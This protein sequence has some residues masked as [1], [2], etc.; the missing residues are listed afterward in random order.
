MITLERVPPT[1]RAN[2]DATVTGTAVEHD[3]P[4]LDDL[5]VR[6]TPGGGRLRVWS[7]NATAM[8]LCLFATKD[9]NW[10]SRRV[11]LVRDRNGVWSASSEFLV[12]GAHYSVRAD[13][14]AGPVHA[15]DPAVHLIDPYARGL[16]RTRAGWRSVVHDDAFDWGQVGKPATRLKDTVIY[17]AHV[18][19]ISKLNPDI[20]QRLRGSYAGLAHPSMIAYLQRLG[21]TA[22]ELLPVQQFTTEQRLVKQGLSN[23][24]GYNTVNFFMP[25]TAYASRGAQATG[26]AAVIREFKGMVRLLHEAGIE[27]ILDVVYNH[28]AEEGRDNPTLSLRG[29]DNASYYRQNAKGDYL[30]VTG[31]GNTLDSSTGAVQRLILDSLRY[32]ANE[33]QVDGFRFD[34]AAALGRG[35][36]DG[37]GVGDFDREH[38]LLTAIVNDPQLAGVK[39]IAEPW[40]VGPGGWQ[41]G[42][43]PDG[44]AEW[45][46]RY[47]DR[48]RDFWLTDIAAVRAAGAPIGI[49]PLAAR[50]AGSADIFAPRRSP[51]ASMNF[52]TA[53]DGFT[54]ADLVSFNHKHNVGNGEN[55]NDGTDHNHS[56]NHGVEGATADESIL[57][58]RRKAM[59]NLLGTL[60]FSAGVPMITAGD[61]FGHSQRG[62]NNAYCQDSELTW[63]S[64]QRLPWQQKLQ[65][66]T[67][68]LIRLR[69][70]HPAL[71][72]ADF[73]VLGKTVTTASRLDWFNARGYSMSPQDWNS[74]EARTLQ[75]LTAEASQE[76]GHDRILLVIHGLEEATTVRLPPHE[77][78]T[79]YVLL[80]DSAAETATVRAPSDATGP[81]EW[82]ETETG[83]GTSFAP[84]TELTVPGTSM[85]LFH[86]L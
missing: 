85:R 27:V 2:T 52:V 64:W 16:T 18:K 74:P 3:T 50:L 12:A 33:M 8:E 60:L 39:L 77:S 19:G 72:P 62:N 1:H 65:S 69:R 68:E 31:C 63:L 73:G 67:S 44:W 79:S 42:N 9:P 83:T 81:G 11:P 38:P 45:N 37:V 41:V 29:L 34:L 36:G 13:G 48:V 30:D 4:A 59:R 66:V 40:D 46:D 5:G 15:F 61:E 28:T 26:P 86:A 47:R 53:H 70:E 20:P 21:I 82:T 14:P 6:L 80:W 56:F 76:E 78:V 84:G 25:H 32:W 24:W 7:A 17:E 22:V 54:L 58:A 55:N 49:G 75:F 10:V 51:L 71:R 43:F 23:Y 57:A 35:P